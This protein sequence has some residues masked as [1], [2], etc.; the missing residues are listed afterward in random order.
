MEAESVLLR[1]RQRAPETERCLQQ[2]ERAD[3]IGL[4]E[5]AGSIDRAVDVAFRREMHH[6]VGRKALEQ[7]AH[8]RRI[9]DVSANKGI[10]RV[11]RHGC[12]R[13]EI[14]RIG[15]LVDHQHLMRRLADDVTHNGGAD[16]PRAAGD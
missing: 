3:N 9:G 15:E 12:E 2:R 6:G 11:V 16:E 13:V 8:P 5:L 10:A 7:F 14:A 4:D 1:A